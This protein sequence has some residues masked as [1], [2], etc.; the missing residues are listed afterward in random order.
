VHLW[1]GFGEFQIPTSAAEKLLA[2]PGFERFDL[3]ANG[4]LRDGQFFGG[5]TQSAFFSD[6]Q[7]IQQV[8]AVEPLHAETL[9]Q[10]S[11]E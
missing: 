2:Q 1:A 3:R 8:M 7:K 5:L 6:G 9:F 11:S 4:G 10:K